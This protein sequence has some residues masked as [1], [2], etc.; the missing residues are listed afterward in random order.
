[1]RSKS[2]RKRTLPTRSAIQKVDSKKFLQS[3]IQ[4][5]LAHEFMLEFQNAIDYHGKT[6]LEFDK[7]TVWHAGP[8][9]Q[10]MMFLEICNLNTLLSFW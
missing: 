9:D 1:L 5:K 10:K 7:T 2:T 4:S 8:D 3:N 6:I